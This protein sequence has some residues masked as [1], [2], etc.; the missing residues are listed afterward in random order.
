M[1]ERRRRDADRGV[2]KEPEARSKKENGYRARAG[3]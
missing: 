1:R 2:T 3:R